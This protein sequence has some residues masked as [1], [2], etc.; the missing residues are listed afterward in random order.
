MDMIPVDPHGA[1]WTTAAAT[2]EVKVFVGGRGACAATAHVDILPLRPTETFTNGLFFAIADGTDDRDLVVAVCQCLLGSGAGIPRLTKNTLF[3][4]VSR[5][6]EKLALLNSNTQ[7]KVLSHLDY[8][9]D[10][11]NTLAAPFKFPGCYEH[12]GNLE[13]TKYGVRNA[14]A[15]TNVT[16]DAPR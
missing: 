3:K 11:R 1:S 10:I 8:A 16:G 6:R 14:P 4:G 5:V 7:K 12:L 9:S 15:T 13:A 2:V